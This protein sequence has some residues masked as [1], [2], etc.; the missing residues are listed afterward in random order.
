MLAVIGA[1]GRAERETM[2]ERQKEG[3]ARARRDGKY[4]GRAPTVR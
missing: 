2:L 3:I 4:K 1:V